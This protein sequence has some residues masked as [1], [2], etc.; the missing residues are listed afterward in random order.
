MKDTPAHASITLARKV[1]KLIDF[2]SGHGAQ[3]ARI[4]LDGEDYLYDE[5]RIANVLKWPVGNS[6]KITIKAR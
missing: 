2:P 6:V 1:R 3:Q 4:A 5:V